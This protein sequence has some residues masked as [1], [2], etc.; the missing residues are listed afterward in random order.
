MS[1]QPVSL[2]RYPLQ[3]RL[4]HSSPLFIVFSKFKF[5]LQGCLLVL[6]FGLSGC[7]SV[8][9]NMTN[10]MAEDLSAAILNSN[11][12]NTVRQGIPAYLLLI[13]SFLLKDPENQSLLLAAA[14][15]NGAFTYFV[16]EDQGQLLAE[17]A[18]AYAGRAACVSREGLCNP[19]KLAFSEY[20]AAIT[21]LTADDVA[22]FYS[23][24]VAWTTWI[25][26]NSGDWNA[27]AQLAK[28]RLLMEKIIDLDETFDNGGPHLYMGGLETVLPAA[29]GG[30]P[31]IGRDH[32]ERSLAIS[33][34]QFLMAKVVYAEQYARLI[35]D[36]ALHDRLLNEVLEANPVAGEMTLINT[37]AQEKAR[38]LLEDGKEYF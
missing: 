2:L 36:Q 27:I 29:M 34:G 8:V 24:G 25:Q 22:V 35:F 15:L 32:F 5:W 1:L 7:A 19:G 18:L 16:D 11:D 23:L 26:L 21:T 33:K 10:Q 28:V 17:K 14:Q 12:I 38:W 13:D 20:E 30:R 9:S 37:L 6:L 4:L 3:C 31:D